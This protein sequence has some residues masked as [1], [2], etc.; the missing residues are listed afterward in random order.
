VK[1][2]E[3]RPILL[4][5]NN[6]DNGGGVNARCQAS[7]LSLYDSNRLKGPLV[8]GVATN[9]SLIDKEVINKLKECRKKIVLLSSTI[10]SPSTK[11]LL[12]EFKNKYDNFELVQYDAVSKNSIL[13]GNKD[14][15]GTSFIPTFNFSKAEVIVSFSADFLGEWIDPSHA[16]QYTA[17]RRPENGKMSMHYQFESLLSTTGANADKRIPIKPSEEPKYILSLYN[18]LLLL[19][20][21]SELSPVNTNHNS[22]IKDIAKSLYQNKSRSL[23]VSNNNDKNVQII[24][25]AIN[26]LL[27]NY[28]HTISSD[29]KSY[30]FC[31]LYSD[32]K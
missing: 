22:L 12:K 10:I 16:R 19:S 4:S 3:G 32:I 14:S 7:V 6:L 20:G 23:V 18:H 1:N 30:V 21:Q 27:K 2:R 24:V 11:K 9:W 29:T 25:N 28:G 26:E 17:N 13:L 31:A 8:N 5:S 15:F